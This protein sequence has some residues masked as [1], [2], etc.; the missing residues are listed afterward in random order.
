MNNKAILRKKIGP[1]LLAAFMLIMVYFFSNIKYTFSSETQILKWVSA[2]RVLLANRQPDELQENYVLINVGYDKMLVDS[3]R[4]ENYLI[5]GNTDIT[6]RQKLIELLELL[7][8]NNNYKY[9]MIDVDLTR[10]YKTIYDDSL[11][12]ILS[13]MDRI[14]IGIEG[15]NANDIYDKRIKDLCFPT[16]YRQTFLESNMLKSPLL[17]DGRPS[18]SLK[19]YQ[20]ITEREIKKRLGLFYSDG[21]SLSRRTI[22]PELYFTESPDRISSKGKTVTINLLYYNLGSRI[23][24][25]YKSPNRAKAFFKD[26]IIVV[27]TFN[28]DSYDRHDTY[29]GEMSGALIEVNEL[30]SLLKGNHR[31]SFWVFLLF[32]SIFFILSDYLLNK[33]HNIIDNASLDLGWRKKT[34]R[35]LVVPIALIWTYYSIV[36]IVL[37]AIIFMLTGEL[38]DVYFTST[39]LTIIDVIIRKLKS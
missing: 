4:D 38:Y 2:I 11:F 37:V 19:V 25:K 36:L 18:L 20:D 23:L 8:V 26:K 9:L 34:F 24:K 16:N 28:K 6:D 12:N 27:G 30:Q 7:K 33:N 22:Y 13:T 3:V 29:A 21:F 5:A 32:F 14:A 31:V 39:F 10:Q 17:F 35:A 15:D 1:F